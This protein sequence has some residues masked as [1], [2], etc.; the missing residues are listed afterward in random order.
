MV[1]ALENEL[2]KKSKECD[3]KQKALKLCPVLL[4]KS[5]SMLGICGQKF[6]LWRRAVKQFVLYS[7]KK[8]ELEGKLKLLKDE[9][10]Y[11]RGKLKKKEG[12][13]KKQR[14]EDIK[15]ENIEIVDPR[16]S[17][18]E[19]IND[20]EDEKQP[21]EPVGSDSMLQVGEDKLGME[22]L[23]FIEHQNKDLEEKLG[24]EMESMKNKAETHNHQIDVSFLSDFSTTFLLR[25]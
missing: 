16:T 5:D 12:E 20:P 24:S 2:E 25:N 19:N 1:V 22:Y 7:A 21:K 10:A 8:A 14:T 9:N 4:R 23:A 3:L 6:S 17:H 18:E 13:E 15:T 11:L